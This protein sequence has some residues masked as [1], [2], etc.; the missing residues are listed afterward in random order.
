MT[1]GVDM[2]QTQL[3]ARRGGQRAACDYPGCVALTGDGG[4]HCAVH[5]A[6]GSDA[7]TI[8]KLAGRRPPRAKRR[9]DDPNASLWLP[10][11]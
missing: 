5:R 8:K 11:D 3:N 2:T 1:K 10:L 7:K 6:A 9:A 4:L